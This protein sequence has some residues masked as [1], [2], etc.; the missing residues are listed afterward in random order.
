[1]IQEVLD[2]CSVSDYSLRVACIRIMQQYTFEQ[3]D[4]IACESK[5]H[6][7][8]SSGLSLQPGQKLLEGKGIWVA[9]FI[10]CLTLNLSLD[11]DFRFMRLSPKLDSVLSVK[12]A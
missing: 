12:P 11:Y 9:Q 3:G 10:R 2:W 5:N 1:M 7:Y 6:W 8:S 4:F